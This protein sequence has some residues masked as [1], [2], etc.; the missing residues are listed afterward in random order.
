MMMMMMMMIED[1]D[2]YIPTTHHVYVYTTN[3]AI[4]RLSRTSISQCPGCCSN[5]NTKRPI[6]NSSETKVRAN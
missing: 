5:W 6:A 1:D 3:Q 2:D 4:P